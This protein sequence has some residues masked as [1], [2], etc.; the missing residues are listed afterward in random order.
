M[1]WAFVAFLSLALGCIEV[2]IPSDDDGSGVDGSIDGTVNPGTG[3]TTA[4]GPDPGPDLE[5]V[6]GTGGGMTTGEIE[7]PDSCESHCDC[8]PAYDCINLRCV[9]G[10]EA[11][12]CCS[13]P[14]CPPG[15]ACW[16]KDGTPGE[17]QGG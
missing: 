3:G 1:R 10:D 7:L 17:C 15:E 14:G 6:T 13:H 12:Q 5:N 11:I 2:T 16:S 4:A 8:P 9:Q